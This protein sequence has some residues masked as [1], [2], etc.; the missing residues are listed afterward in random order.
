[1]NQDAESMAVRMAKEFAA[2]V[3]TRMKNTYIPLKIYV[4]LFDGAEG[5]ILSY[6]V[7]DC[8]SRDVPL[9]SSLV[10]AESNAAGEANRGV[11]RIR[12]LLEGEG[13]DGIRVA[14][15]SRAGADRYLRVL[16]ISPGEGWPDMYE[17][18]GRKGN[19]RF[20]LNFDES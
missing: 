13:T 12:E 14:E 6:R 2:D 1:M 16:Q 15:V 4:K 17:N 7:K 11:R 3:V 5:R 9:E 10:V 20:K 19:G 8:L 18:G